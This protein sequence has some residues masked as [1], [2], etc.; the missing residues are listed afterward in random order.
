MLASHKRI[1]GDATQPR[2]ATMK[3]E[4]PLEILA[5]QIAKLRA[6]PSDAIPMKPPN[7]ESLVR[8]LVFPVRLSFG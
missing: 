1:N 7:A 2:I 4:N 6:S 8:W 5:V 3:N